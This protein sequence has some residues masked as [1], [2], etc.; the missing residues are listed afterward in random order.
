[1]DAE[2]RDFES[3][4][5]EIRKAAR[6]K[7]NP[8]WFIIAVDKVDLYYEDAQ[9]FDAYAHYARKD[10]EFYERVHELVGRMGRDNVAVDLIPVCSWPEDFAWGEQ[11]VKSSLR[12]PER[13][14]LILGLLKSL[15]SLSGRE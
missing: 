7:G 4:A 12:I 6:K 15:D 3:T 5:Q 11:V 8:S 14:G 13:D 10:G 1:M 2:L 9:L